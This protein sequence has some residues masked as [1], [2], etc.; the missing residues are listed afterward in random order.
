MEIFKKITGFLLLLLGLS[1]HG[2]ECPEVLYPQDG[3]SNIPV[4]ATIRW[5]DTDID[6]ITS[7][8]ISIGLTPGG[9]EIVTRQSAGRTPQFEL[10]C[11]IPN[12]S[13]L[14]V[15]LYIFTLTQGFIPCS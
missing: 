1:L 11:G 9:E 12:N 7:W 4:D 2:Q 14:Y 8:A 6:L 13:T 15:E 3:E 10:P 5:T